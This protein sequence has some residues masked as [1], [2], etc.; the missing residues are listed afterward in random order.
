[1]EWFALLQTFFLFPLLCYCIHFSLLD[2]FSFLVFCFSLFL[3]F[4]DFAYFSF[5]IPLLFFS[6]CL[7]LSFFLPLIYSICFSPFICPFSLFFLSLS[8][9][10]CGIYTVRSLYFIFQFQ[11]SLLC[12]LYCFLLLLNTILYMRLTFF[13]FDWKRS[14]NKNLW[15]QAVT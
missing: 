1:M 7:S 14:L 8:H 4:C 13:L 11:P 6:I 2:R 3:T 12:C 10:L 5:K 9:N 15:I